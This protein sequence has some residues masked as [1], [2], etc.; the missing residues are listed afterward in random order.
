M[1]AASH[2]AEWL[3]LV[4]HSGPFLTLPVLQRVFPQQLEALEPGLRA[5]TRDAL[6]DWRE[7]PTQPALH[8]AWI[9]HVLQVVLRHPDEV[10]AEGQSIPPGLEAR[11]LEHGEVLR[12]DFVLL[13]PAGHAEPRRPRLLISVHPPGTDLSKPLPDRRWK[14]SPASRMA[15]LCHAANVPLG[16]VT[17]GDHWL[18]VWAP[19]GETTG[20]ASW[21]AHLWSE[22]PLTFRAF[23]SLL[24]AS[25]FFAVAPS[26][27]L[28]ALYTESSRDQSEVTDQLGLQVRQA[29]QVLIQ[30]LDRLDAT[31]GRTLLAHTS[32]RDLYN[33]AL[34]VMMRL[35]FLF[36][37][38]EKG[39]L[40]LGNHLYDEHYAVSTL[41][42]QLR[43]T[44]DRHG[45]E[46][47]ESRHD[48]WCRLLATFRAIHGG[49]EHDELRLPAYGGGLFD[50]DRYP[51]LEGRPANTPWQSTPAQ[52]LEIN[53]RVVLHLLEAL[54]TLETKL[55]G[56]RERQRLRL[57]F[58]ALDIEQIGHVYE[59]L[60]DHTA[61]RA[62]EV[63]LGLV[64][65]KGEEPEVSLAKLEELSGGPAGFP[66]A[67]A[68]A[69][70]PTL[71][72]ADAP[73]DTLPFPNRKGSSSY[74]PPEELL[75]FLHEKTGRSKSA[76]KKGLMDRT[77]VDDT[78]LRIAC[79]N[80]ERLVTRITPFSA[81][82]REDTFGRPVVCPQDSLYVTSGSDRRSTGTHYTPRS[83]TEPIVQH[84]LEPL[85]YLGPAEGLPKDQW[86]LKPAK[87]LLALKV[88]DMA[89]GSGA[90]LV[91]TCRYMA[92]RL[93]EAWEIAED[94][95][96]GERDA[97]SEGRGSGGEGRGSGSEGRGSG[98]EGRG[99]GSEG[100][101]SGGE[102][103]DSGG[104]GRDSGGEERDSGSEG[105]DAVALLSNP[106]PRSPLPH[107][108]SPLPVLSG[109]PST[110]DSRHE[111]P[112][113]P[114]VAGL[115]S[116][117]GHGCGVL[118]GDHDLSQ[119]RTLR[120]DQPDPE[121]G[122][123]HPGEHSRRPWSQLDQGIPPSPEHRPGLPSRDRDPSSPCP[124]SGTP[125]GTPIQPTP[126]NL[127][128]HQSNALP[129]PP[130]PG[131]P[132][133]LT[134]P[135]SPQ[136]P[137]P[138]P[139]S[140]QSA[141]PAPRSPHPAP[142]PLLVLPDGSLSLA[143]PSERL[144]PA[145]P[146]ER[147][148]IARRY[149][150]DRCLYG[151]D[152]N[153]M[154]VEMAKLSLWLITLQ[155]DRPFTFLDHALK[156]GDSLL[157]VTSVQQIVNFS[158]RPGDRQ[159]TFAT[160]DLARNVDEASA[161]RRALEDLPS[162][163]NQDIV[164]KN[165]LHAEAEAATAKVKALADCLIAFELRGLDG[166]AY[167]DQRTAEAETVQ[168]LIKL[169]GEREAGGERRENLPPP[170]PAP[171]SPLL[172]HAHERLRGRRPFHWPVEFPE[173]FARGGFDA[174]VG[175]P[176]FIGGHD[177]SGLFGHDYRA[178]L[179][180]HL[181]G[182]KAG[183]ADICAF[184]AVR[185]HRL[186]R[187]G[188]TVGLVAT[189]STTEGDSKKV[190]LDQIVAEGSNIVVAWPDMPWPGNAAVV[191]S[192]FVM[193][194]GKWGGPTFSTTLTLTPQLEPHSLA[195]NQNV[196][197]VGCYVLGD[198]FEITEDTAKHFL[199]ANPETSKV[200]L[201]YINGVEL[202]A[203][204]DLRPR[205][206]IICFWDWA[207]EKAQRYNSVF[208]YLNKSRAS[209][210]ESQNSE[211]QR[212]WW[213]F[214][215]SRPAL[216]HAIGLGNRFAEHPTGWQHNQNW[217]T[218]AIVKAKTSETWAFALLPSATIFDQA[219]TV[220]AND[221][222]GLFAVLQSTIH[223][224]WARGSGAGS[225]MKTDLRYSP[226]NFEAFPMPAADNRLSEIGVVYE[227]L[228]SEIMFK[229]DEGLTDTY[230]RFHDRSEASADIE[231]LRALHV[232]MDQAVALAYG[233]PI[234]V[235]GQVVH[236][237]SPAS[238]SP[239]P[240]PP[241]P[242]LD[243][244][245]GF[246]ATKQGERFTL[247]EPAR[248]TVLDRLLAL[249]HQRYEEEVKAG[250]HDKGAKKPKKAKP[251]TDQRSA[252]G[253]VQFGLGLALPANAER[254]LPTEFRLPASEGAHYTVSLV[255]ALL[256]EAGGSLPLPRLRDAFVLAT[257][258]KLMQRLAP[259]D[260]AARVRAWAQRWCEAAKP[261]M[262]LDSLKAIGAR[263][264]AVSPGAQG[265]IF[266]LLDGPRPPAT[267]DV[268]Y[269]AWI[270]LRVSATLPPSAILIPEVPT[271]TRQA[272][273][274][275]L[276]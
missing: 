89:M 117:H 128:P 260:D 267:E 104:E 71:M 146:A 80:D 136:S 95:I 55:P 226:T 270:A 250:L 239:L 210:E 190:G 170:A 21:F 114:G 232:E 103:R 224:T 94:Q 65:K 91:Q 219:I 101:D 27:T 57:S 5:H 83:L 20:Y 174:F 87:E 90:F 196:C 159:V 28:E 98:S 235:N 240:A 76:L 195:G 69:D 77:R 231:R 148:A 16:L 228:R 140:L 92:E 157:G 234:V 33:A 125:H 272:E 251:A 275:V 105:R 208:G 151:V 81:L 13:N 68:T 263:H 149:V 247:S 14:A 100:R 183:L 45:E 241:L 237:P 118:S 34:T 127:H 216:Y 225:K 161:K 48:A 113:L 203:F 64:G 201:P 56:T 242:P 52:P 102:G 25:R 1:S 276:A 262:F 202:N 165:R 26:D 218:K 175:N 15:E 121:G 258:P 171:R 79:G 86:K 238:P 44:A 75:E 97:G 160:A 134:S 199:A 123:L 30:S 244:G 42:E 49:I 88:C 47:L 167:E 131:T 145:D 40:L 158:L 63:I 221:D 106:A 19:R 204:P 50:P 249:N 115:A 229:N 255:F 109:A 265:R 135:P 253:G 273:E 36:C 155:R 178:W 11:Q 254:T 164:T 111:N 39:L 17:D 126:R 211:E 61:R 217:P 29:V 209:G 162:H 257:S 193:F 133:P 67:F 9:L 93:V 163:S 70:E 72:A 99:S 116:E 184:F 213:L 122:R 62:R 189:N 85:V 169:D 74:S 192:P 271:M 230:N 141:P 181:Y 54:Q 51:F 73:A 252:T 7:Q 4:P 78:Q 37:A 124:T 220:F 132:P 205:R 166:D 227:R 264:L 152:I 150:A 197:F 96:R 43:E 256:S 84:T 233:W 22:E 185:C 200:I 173:V 269:D 187:P 194:R 215:R 41:R 120:P 24:R 259:G 112:E 130:I 58:R 66:E 147:L 12:P 206:W 32:E 274:L 153:P 236:P 142:P 18:L 107:T 177:I 108:R 198:Y 176:P 156:C 168:R 139:P 207:E 180:N 154:A 59:G 222:H 268:G 110:T 214:A 138:A 182:K 23:I 172:A 119:V 144:L 188:A 129:P 212:N 38:E 186:T 248:R 8:R 6:D 261:V 246:H 60:L 2:H 10:L 31:H 53:N 266:Q 3:Q 223:E 46:L 82:L 191:V 35:V 179:A 143:S 245:H 137:P 243:L